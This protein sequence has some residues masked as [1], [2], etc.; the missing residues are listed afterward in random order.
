MSS[1]TKA[2][3][4]LLL[5]T[6]TLNDIKLNVKLLLEESFKHT[7]NNLFIYINPFLSKYLSNDLNKTQNLQLIEERSQLKYLISQFYTN[8]N[9]LNPNVNV[10]CLLNNVHSQNTSNKLGLSY[11]LVL[12]DYIKLKE[13]Q[14]TLKNFISSNLSSGKSVNVP[15][16]LIEC[17]ASDLTIDSEFKLCEISEFDQI[18]K[19]KIYE[20]SIIGGTFDRLHI[21]HKIMLSECALL[22]RNSLLVGIADG[23]LLEKKKLAELIESFDTRCK[24]VTDF[25]RIVAP[26][27]K[28]ITCPIHD[29]FGPSITERDY[30]CLIVSQETVSGGEKVNQKRAENNLPLLDIHV[31]DLVKESELVLNE[32]KGDE[33][34]VS[35]SNERR[36]LLGTLLKPPCVK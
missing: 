7:N 21:G 14:E 33:E 36:H 19:S 28:V 29:P 18:S 4:S 16:K 11:D 20:N 26:R 22:T 9:R 31:I 25:L 5:L 34:K 30:Q 2:T 12:T 13:H 27:L 35:S 3:N 6:Q 10:F 24:N 17:S 23:P 15:F 32:H 1:T 8:S